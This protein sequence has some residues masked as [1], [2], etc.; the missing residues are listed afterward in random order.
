MAMTSVTLSIPIALPEA[1]PYRFISDP[2][3]MPHWA[4]HNVK[5]IRP[6]EQNEWEIQPPAALE[7]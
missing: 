1:E 3:T 2:A 5:S 4:V 7:D 6:L